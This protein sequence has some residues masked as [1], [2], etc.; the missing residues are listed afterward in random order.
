MFSSRNETNLQD[1]LLVAQGVA[2]TVFP[3]ICENSPAAKILGHDSFSQDT[4]FS[5]SL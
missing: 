4:N 1:S 3:N 5:H 2:G